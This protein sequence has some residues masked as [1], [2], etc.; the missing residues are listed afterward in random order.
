VVQAPALYASEPY[1]RGQA[2]AANE[3]GS[4]NSATN[5]AAAGSIVT[6]RLT[7]HRGRKISVQIC[8]RPAEVVSLRE[9]GSGKAEVRVRV[10]VGLAADAA[11]PVRVKAGE[12][13]SQSGV[14]LAVR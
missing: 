6:L 1:G 2:Q 10:P 12:F 5:A 9:M 7:G 14:T 3:D 11:V 4:A 8:G 13:F